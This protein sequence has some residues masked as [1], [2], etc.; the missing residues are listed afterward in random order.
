MKSNTIIED[1]TIS[2]ANIRCVSTPN[3]AHVHS[4]AHPP[5]PSYP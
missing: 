4:Y 1:Q 2:G 5:T 3:H